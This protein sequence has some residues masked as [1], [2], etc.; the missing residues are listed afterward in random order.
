MFKEAVQYPDLP[1]Y[2]LLKKL[3]YEQE[4]L[5]FTCCGHP[6]FFLKQERKFPS[7]MDLDSLSSHINE[8]I[9][10]AG[11]TIAARSCRISRNRTMGF[12]TIED[13]TGTAEVALSPDIYARYRRIIYSKGP[14]LV[15]GPV[16]ERH[17]S[18]TI[19]AHRVIS[20][21]STV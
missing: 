8:D 3:V 21:L 12:M 5:G 18:L 11:I 16:R 20:Q 15:T 9:R 17:G 1:E 14:F 13:E 10:A 19:Q 6:L 2:P 4:V 7:C